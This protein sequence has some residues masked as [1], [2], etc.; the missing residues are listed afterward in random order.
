MTVEELKKIY[1]SIPPTNPI[2]R[3]RRAAIMRQILILLA[4]G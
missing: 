3:A 4:G 1:D 2:N